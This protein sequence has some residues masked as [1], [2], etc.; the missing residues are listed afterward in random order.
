MFNKKEDLRWLEFK[1][2]FDIPDEIPLI[3][4]NKIVD[5]VDDFEDE[6]ISRL[7]QP[8]IFPAF[9]FKQTTY[10]LSHST[11]KVIKHLDNLLINI[12]QRILLY[13]Y[14]V[15]LMKLNPLKLKDIFFQ[16]KFHKELE[17]TVKRLEYELNIFKRESEEAEKLDLIMKKYDWDRIASELKTIESI[18]KK[19]VYLINLKHDYLLD[20]K[21]NIENLDY[22][23]ILPQCEI[24]M[25]RLKILLNFETNSDLLLKNNFITS[26]IENEVKDN[27]SQQDNQNNKDLFPEIFADG[28]YEA[29]VSLNEKYKKDNKASKAKYSY[30]FHFLNYEGYLSCNQNDYIDFLIEQKYIDKMSKIQPENEKYKSKIQQLLVRYLKG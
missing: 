11:D 2:E 5:T 18:D 4:Y 1:L 3:Y 9:L 13:I 15:G 12:G 16:V 14:M 8:K 21:N 10:A 23:D 17:I 20:C 22:L 6:R 24:E 28:G 29:F 30:M 26:P 19:L 7:F 27:Q 25:E